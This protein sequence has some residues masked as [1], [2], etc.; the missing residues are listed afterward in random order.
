MK[1]VLCHTDFSLYW[2]PRILA[3][4]KLCV[5]HGADLQVIQIAGKGSPYEF[6]RITDC[7][8]VAFPWM[9]LYP[10][11]TMESLHSSV[12]SK[13]LFSELDRIKPD[14]ILA[15]AIAYPS[16]ATAVRWARRRKRAVVIM[17]DARLKDVPRSCLVNW[18]KRRI[19]ANVDALLI[20]AP[21]HTADYEFWGVDID[22]M[23]FGI[24]VVDNDFFSKDSAV[25]K[26]SPEFI[27]QKY[28]LPEKYILGVGRQIA[29]KN[30]VLL[31]RAFVAV[32]AERRAEWGLVLVGDGPEA[33]NLKHL[34]ASLDGKVI[35][36]P[37]QSQRALCEIYSLADCL[38]LPSF[39]ETWGLVVNEAMACGL[40]VMV[41]KE[42]GCAR[43]LVQDGYNGW[44]FDPQSPA[45]LT[46][47]LRRFIDIPEKEKTQMGMRSREII[48]DWGIE[49]FCRGAWAT[50]QACDGVNRSFASP[51]DRVI[52]SLWKGRYR[53][54]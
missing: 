8:T 11:E 13:R 10:H 47:L 33:E 14:V 15:G 54:T 29:K 44:V 53:P 40:P 27:R 18:V 52:L 24:D 3:L 22:R 37:F 5:A 35:F 51:V 46:A 45:Y 49:R 42:C 9:C 48:A 32:H 26:Y 31:I 2:L 12:V 17:D 25:A 39:G 7:D 43:T 19:Y 28:A 23:F 1:V 38:V 6:A 20:P 36:L 34:A 50:V 16:G 41:S 4:K 30:W 21:S